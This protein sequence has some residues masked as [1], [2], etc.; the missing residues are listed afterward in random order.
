[1]CLAAAL[2]PFAAA[3]DGPRVILRARF[4]NPPTLAALQDAVLPGSIP[5]TDP[6]R[7]GSIFSGLYRAPS[8]P[9]DTFWATIDRGPNNGR[10]V[11]G[12]WRATFPTPTFAPT[13]LRVRV[14]RPT[15][16][17]QIDRT[18]PL[19]N[20]AGAPL[21]G[22]PNRP[23]IDET[24]WDGAATTRLDYDPDGMDPEAVVHAP[25]GTFWLAEE[26]GPSVVHVAA[27]GH[28]LGR[29]VPEGSNLTAKGYKIFE[30]LPQPLRFRQKNRGFEAL[31]ISRDGSKLFALVQSPLVHPVAAASGLSRTIRLGVIDTGTG[32]LV[33]GYVFMAEPALAYRETRQSEVKVGDAVWVN[34]HTLLIVERTDKFARLYQLDLSSASNLL[35]EPMAQG[36]ELEMASPAELALRGI[37]FIK[38]TLLAD[39]NALVPDLP[40]KIEGLA[41]LDAHTVVIGNDNEFGARGNPEDSQLFYIHLPQALPVPPEDPHTLANVDEVRPSHLS[42]DLSLD[43]TSHRI[44]GV[45]EITLAYAEGAKP[46]FLDLDTRD[47]AIARVSDPATGRDYAFTLGVP[48][49][50]LGRQLRIALAGTRPEKVRIEYE[51]SPGARAVQWLTPQ[52]TTS[53]KWPFVFTQSQA[54]HARTWMPTADSPGV[55]VTYDATVHVPA[56]MHVVMSA[57]HVLDEPATGTFRFR[58]AQSIPAYLI[59]LAAGEIAFKSLGPRTGVYAEPAV[60]ER[61]AS[62]FR[63]VE[64]MVEAAETIY[65]PYRWGRWDTIVLPPSFPYGGMENPRVTFATPTIIAGDR[66]LVDVMAHELAHSWSGNLVTNGTWADTWLNEGFTTYFEN[67][68]VEQLYGKELADMEML[69][70]IRTM[71]EVVAEGEASH[72]LRPTQLMQEL[73]GRDPEDGS[74]LAYDKGAAVL[75]MLEAHFGRE[76]LDAFLRSY[77]DGHALQSMTTGRFVEILREGLFKDDPAAWETL[78]VEDWIYG[79]GLPDNVVVPKSERFDRTRAAADAFLK[80][81]AVD[82]IHGDWVTVEWLDFLAALPDPLTVAQM[83]ALDK[84]AGFTARGNAEI[85]CVWLEHAIKADYEP[86]YTALERFLT[87]QGRR[88]FLRPLYAAM[89]QNPKTRDMGKRTY[90]KARPTYHPIAVATIDEILK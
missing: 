52:Q 19:R 62:E 71:R 7:V 23:E 57:E 40:Q 89:Q 53:G 32:K 28:V 74:A 66:S 55:R 9:P 69:L 12:A 10:V 75:H 56:G 58:M 84:A 27:D 20:D 90:A 76:R 37:G 60:L 68:I 82:G 51:T 35:D 34:D 47:L 31:A 80:T 1:L 5:A 41:I 24:P 83:T 6:V 73:T 8:D 33:A 25:D 14:D 2:A 70:Q 87:S 36:R 79:P 49:P 77:F 43:F 65:G 39:L 61:A 86:A 22:L 46:A 48:V 64:K 18:L 29:Y 30:T 21:T 3:E 45:N 4:A 17:I 50:F 42:L 26:Y 72:D 88:K 13:I 54:H 85:L 38:K 81:G 63:D 15:G 44:R 78:H 59:A 16:T 67:R 11:A